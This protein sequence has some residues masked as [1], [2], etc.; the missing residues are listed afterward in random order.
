M[1][2]SWPSPVQSQY[3]LSAQQDLTYDKLHTVRK[4]VQIVTASSD[5]RDNARP[6]LLGT[7]QHAGIG[8]TTSRISFQ[9]TGSICCTSK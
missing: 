2:V 6:T 9:L 3:R 8:V 4:E 1:S 5:I 7:L